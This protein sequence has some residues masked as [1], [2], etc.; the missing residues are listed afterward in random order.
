M[1]K[2]TYTYHLDE[3]GG[4]H[5][6][7]S[8]SPDGFSG[9]LY[10]GMG[11]KPD[12]GPE[13][14]HE[15]AYSVRQVQ[16]W[17]SV[18]LVDVPKEWCEAI[19]YEEQPEPT[20]EPDLKFVIKDGPPRSEKLAELVQKL[21]DGYTLA[22]PKPKP[23]PKSVQ[24]H[25]MVDGLSVPEPALTQEDRFFEDVFGPAEPKGFRLPTFNTGNDYLDDPYFVPVFASIVAIFYVLFYCL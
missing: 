1:K 5:G 13:S 8:T 21:N 25:V 12:Q 24:P 22:P 10:V 18:D 20:P 23:T 2:V 15:Q 17:K 6:V 16:K 9:A 4:Y 19:G 14:V 3:K 7:T 11:P